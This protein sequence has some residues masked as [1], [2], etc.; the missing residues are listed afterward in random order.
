MRSTVPPSP[1]GEGRG[2]GRG[3]HPLFRFAFFPSMSAH[4]RLANLRRADSAGHAK[5]LRSGMTDAE[6]ALWYRLR[7]RRFEG[8]K[9]RRQVPV[10]PYV[11]DFLCERAQLVIEID[12]GQHAEQ[13]D[14]DM[15]RSRWLD[16]RGYRVLRFWNNEVLENLEGVLEAIRQAV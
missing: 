16:A 15:V 8:M 14:W 9:F 3:V 2:E 11:A 10:G 5:S 13:T 4:S 6:G 1:L 12:G 7:G